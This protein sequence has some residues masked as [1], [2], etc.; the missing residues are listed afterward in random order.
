MTSSAEKYRRFA[1]QCLEIA[2]TF[3][4]EEA[5]ATLLGFARA[6][7]RLAY[8]AQA[9]RQIAELAVQIARQ[10]VIVK[11]ALDEGQP[12]EIAE[13]LLHALEESLG[14][15]E[16]HSRELVLD[17]LNEAKTAASCQLWCRSA[18]PNALG[19]D[20]RDSRRKRPP[21]PKSGVVVPIVLLVPVAVR[22]PRI[23]GIVVPGTAAD[24]TFLA[25]PCRPWTAIGR[26]PDVVRIPAILHPL[27]HIAGH[28]E[29]AE[30]IGLELA[31][32]GGFQSAPLVFAAMAI[33]VF[34]VE[35]VTPVKGRRGAGTSCVFPFG[36]GK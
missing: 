11:H 19:G 27:P 16:K 7:L 2:P 34:Y 9:N 17:Q 33:G 26:R 21:D 18:V 8:L 5:R 36:L 3:Q 35:L 4:D 6:W 29:E 24:D 14:A 30:R 22:R 20:R 23:C 25:I 12:S 28:V 15:F 13:S 31:D 32:R 1:R 10:R